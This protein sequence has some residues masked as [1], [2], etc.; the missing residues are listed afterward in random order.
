MLVG[1]DI[2]A[3]CQGT[4]TTGNIICVMRMG[5]VSSEKLQGTNVGCEIMFQ[6]SNRF[7]LHIESVLPKWGSIKQRGVP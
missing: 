2:M 7:I 1:I 6:L 5:P 3:V 4:V